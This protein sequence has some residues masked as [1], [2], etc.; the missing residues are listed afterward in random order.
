MREGEGKSLR[1]RFIGGVGKGPGR[2]PMESLVDAIV[3]EANIMVA[4]VEGQ[5]I[6]NSVE[7]RTKI[8][9]RSFQISKPKPYRVTHNT[10]TI[11]GGGRLRGSSKLDPVL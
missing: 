8:I 4:M 10:H 2:F 3:I 5:D 7:H 6:I 9:S 11:K 1:R